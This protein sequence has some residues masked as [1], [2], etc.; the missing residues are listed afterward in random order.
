MISLGLGSQPTTECGI[1]SSNYS[2]ALDGNSDYV[3]CPDTLKS[4]VDKNLGTVSFW[5][6]VVENDGATSQNVFKIFTDTDN[7]FVVLFH[8]Y[9]TEWRA[10]LKTDGQVRI[11]SYDIPGS[12]DNDGSGYDV[13]WQHFAASWNVSGGAYSVKLYRNGSLIQNTTGVSGQSDWVGDIDSINIGA[14]QTG[15]GAFTDGHLDQVALWKIELDANV[16]NEIY[17]HGVIRDLTTISGARYYTTNMVNNL[18]GYYQ[19][20]NN[21]L[22]SSNT[23]AHG[24]LAGTAQ[25]VTNQP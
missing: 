9:Y 25:F 13:G 4:A 10:S 6:N 14:N 7:Q 23:K 12:S 19:F 8:K 24:T 21:A 2:L 11:A 15:T 16:I 18:I 20:E 17:N 3:S 5:V 1:F 22:D